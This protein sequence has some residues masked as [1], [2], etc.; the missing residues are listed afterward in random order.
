MGTIRQI[1]DFFLKQRN[2]RIFEVLGLLEFGNRMKQTGANRFDE[3]VRRDE[4]EMFIEKYRFDLN[5][6]PKRQVDIDP[7]D[8]CLDYLG[9]LPHS[10]NPPNEFGESAKS[11]EEEARR[12][13]V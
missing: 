9:W 5:K 10:I 8:Y 3:A 2:P 11:C 13:K 1:R 12:C 6:A 7:W 4:F